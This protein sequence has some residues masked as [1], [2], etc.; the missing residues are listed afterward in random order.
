MALSF[1]RIL[2]PIDFDE[3][4]LK[5][6]DAAADLAR[7]SA[8]TVYVMHVL[9]PTGSTLTP[10]DVDARVAEEAAAKGRLTN[11][12]R[13]RLD[14]LSYDVITRTGDPAIGI[15]RAEEEVRA[16]LVVIATHTSR[17]KPR[18]F[19]GSVAERVI[20][21]S[22]CPVVS[23]RPSAAGDPDAVASHMTISPLS[24]SPGITVA[25]LRKMMLENRIRSI[26]VV[27]GDK[28]VGMVTDRDI[29]FS[30]TTPECAIGLLMTDEVVTVSPRTSIQ[31]AARILFECEVDGLPVVE[32][33]RLVGIITRSDILRAFA[34]VDRPTLGP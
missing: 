28:V 4:S 10:A 7:L 32:N 17:T 20:R 13:D 29:A 34:R 18:G 14:D 1:K 27:E 9:V 8:A 25:R 26:P 24:V 15:I 2:S 22:L 3:N 11:I 21:E 23:I 30:D 6:L 12:C 16:D 31:E 33:Q 5:A 19:P